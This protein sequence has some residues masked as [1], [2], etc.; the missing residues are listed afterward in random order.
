MKRTIVFLFCVAS[1]CAQTKK[2]PHVVTQSGTAVTGMQSI[3][4]VKFIG[5]FHAYDP[6]PKCNVTG[7]KIVSVNNVALTVTAKPGTQITYSCS[8]DRS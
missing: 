1:L 7:G 6:M 4:L 3:A 2:A 8:V 5:T